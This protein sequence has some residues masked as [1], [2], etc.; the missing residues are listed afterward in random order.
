MKKKDDIIKNMVETGADMTGSVGGAVIGA[1]IAGPAG[2]VVGGISGPLITRAFK[3]IGAEIRKRVT[4]SREE[5]RI[6]AA[7][8]FALKKL[9]EN[10]AEGKTLRD[11]K[12]SV[13]Y[14]FEAMI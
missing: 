2:S 6:G 11:G 5:V 8:T 13:S 12:H 7:Y 3:S 4:G 1:L 9:S 14:I 10:M